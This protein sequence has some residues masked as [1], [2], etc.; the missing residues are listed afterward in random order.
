MQLL[1]LLKF[2]QLDSQTPDFEGKHLSFSSTLHSQLHRILSN[3]VLQ[4][5]PLAKLILQVAACLLSQCSYIALL[6]G[7]RKM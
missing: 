1:A 7:D 3:I 6:S 4:S 2:L 5:F